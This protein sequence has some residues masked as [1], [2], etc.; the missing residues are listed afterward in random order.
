MNRLLSFLKAIPDNGLT[1]D[2]ASAIAMA[3]FLAVAAIWAFEL[4]L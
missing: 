4:P 2:I 3:A 1:Q